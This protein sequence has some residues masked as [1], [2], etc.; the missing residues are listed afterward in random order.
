M[1]LFKHR[2]QEHGSQFSGP[3]CSYCGSTHT[4]VR[5]DQAGSVKTWRGQRYITC[6]CLD[7]GKDFYAEEPLPESRISV[8][9]D[10]R[11]VENEA[12]LQAA[13]EELKREIEDEDDRRFG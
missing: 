4:G 13:E 2:S 1:W 6:R 11:I 3:R 12:E 7:C 8:I 10:D 9:E 5:E